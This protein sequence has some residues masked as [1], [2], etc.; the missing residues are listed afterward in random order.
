[1]FENLL[2][3]ELITKRNLPIWLEDESQRLGLVNI[4]Q[5]LWQTMRSAPVFF[6]EIPFEER[7]KQIIKEY[8]H[9]NKEKIQDAILRIKKRLGGLETKNAVNYLLEGNTSSCFEILLRHYDKQYTKGLHARN[10]LESLLN[11]ISSAH[12]DENKNAQKIIASLYLEKF[13]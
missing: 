5:A 12:V 10:N 3:V 13:A 6:L 1:M 7:L 4:P 2:A 8:G 9:L 11:K